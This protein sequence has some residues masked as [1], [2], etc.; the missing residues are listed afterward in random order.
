MH[1]CT[2][3]HAHTPGGGGAQALTWASWAPAVS[4]APGSHSRGRTGSAPPPA[5]CSGADQWSPA[6]G[7]RGGV[8]EEGPGQ[9]PT[10]PRRPRNPL[11]QGGQQLVRLRAV[12]HLDHL[13]PAQADDVTQGLGR[14][15]MLLGR[16]RELRTPVCPG[17]RKLHALEGGTCPRG[18]R[19]AQTGGNTWEG[20]NIGTG[21]ER[22][23]RERETKEDFLEKETLTQT[24]H[25]PSTASGQGVQRPKHART[26]DRTGHRGPSIQ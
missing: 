20:E 17:V 10:L 3:A 22:L 5:C 11:L 4:A 6:W 9:L 7:R 18:Q 24:P 21:K 12:L 16:E 8:K 14:V 19:A 13:L 23:P 1:T 26:Q 2:R 25:M 15:G